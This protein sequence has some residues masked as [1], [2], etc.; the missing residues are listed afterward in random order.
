MP[1]FI[2]QLAFPEG[3]MLSAAKLGVIV[4]SVVAAGLAAAVTS[5]RRPLP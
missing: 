1:W 5:P 3:P 4:G 2:A